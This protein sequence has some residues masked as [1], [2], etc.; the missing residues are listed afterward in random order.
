M[1]TDPGSQRNTGPILIGVLF[2][3][4]VVGVLSLFRIGITGH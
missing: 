1:A 4:L 2:F 3:A